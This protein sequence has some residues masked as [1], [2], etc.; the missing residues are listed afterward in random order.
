MMCTTLK[1]IAV[2]LVGVSLEMT[3]AA[4]STVTET[5]VNLYNCWDYEIH[6]GKKTF[7]EAKNECESIQNDF[8]TGH[9]AVI[10]SEVLLN[11]IK[12]T[13]TTAGL[14]TKKCNQFGFWIAYTDPDQ[15]V[16]E[17]KHTSE[18][19]KWL[20]DSCTFF[21][22]WEKGQPNDNKKKYDHSGQNC[23]QLWYRTNKKGKVLGEGYFDD[24]YCRE[25]KGYVCQ[26]PAGCGPIK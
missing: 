25:K 1:V 19:F 13:V 24:E 21:E 14:N 16:D 15:T 7:D 17:Y 8:G 23:V 9:L 5:S 11:G 4:A 10:Q 26:V 12:E 3:G 20:Y 2:L 18:D 6:C 22:R